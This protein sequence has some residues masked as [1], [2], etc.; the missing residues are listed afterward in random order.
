LNEQETR[1]EAIR[2]L[3]RGI[4]GIVK[5]LAQYEEQRRHLEDVESLAA[6]LK[7]LLETKKLLEFER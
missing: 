2:T 4:A 5:E 1:Q 7:V 6:R 3:E